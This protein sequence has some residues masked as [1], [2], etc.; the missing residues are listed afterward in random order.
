MYKIII[1]TIRGKK[2]IGTCD[3]FELEPEGENLYLHLYN[4]VYDANNKGV[5]EM[6]VYVERTMVKSI[7]IKEIPNE[8]V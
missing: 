7:K 2:Q 5:A 8:K 1:K 3:R 6:D 4:N